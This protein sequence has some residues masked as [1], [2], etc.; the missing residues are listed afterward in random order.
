MQLGNACPSHTT[1]MAA[2][3]VWPTHD[4]PAF[5]KQPLEKGRGKV[6]LF[7]MEAGCMRA[8]GMWP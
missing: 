2:L 5:V 3:K 4:V 1:S 8:G 7:V 6:L